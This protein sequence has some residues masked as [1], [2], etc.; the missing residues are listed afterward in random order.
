MR[1]ICSSTSSPLAVAAA[2]FLVLSL[3]SAALAVGEGDGFVATLWGDYSAQDA[4]EAS[5]MAEAAGARQISFLVHMRQD[6]WR[7][8]EV[9]F[10]S[11][12]A[13][14][15]FDQAPAR[16]VLEVV[17]PDARARGL[18]VTLVPFILPDGGGVPRQRFWPRDRAGWFRSYGARIGE[19]A[20]FAERESVDEIIIGSELSSLYLDESAWRGV[21][22]D[23]RGRFHGHLTLSTLFFEYATIRF[24]DALDSIGVSG[25]FPLTFWTG[26]RGVRWLESGWRFHRAHLLAFA[27]SRGKSL[28][29]S[30]VGYPATRVA[31]T[32]PWDYDWA[33]RSKD[34]EL[35]KRCFEAFRR[36]WSGEPELRRF[37]IWGLQSVSS[38]QH[39]S[40][41]KG[42]LPIGKAA[43]PTVRQLFGERAR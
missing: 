29:F 27:R 34:E 23:V 39:G 37:S 16:A 38:D 9:R 32:Q 41:G 5:A 42:F 20:D 26:I 10:Q 40:S 24:W 17:I 14:T 7:A 30:E 33:A 6:D 15:P 19:L 31:A 1:K 18:A 21:I 8:S 28:T 4:I 12:Q 2:A 22:G 3:S 25:Y 13:G 36:V 35:Q 43:E 11:T